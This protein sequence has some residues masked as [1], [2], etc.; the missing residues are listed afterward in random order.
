MNKTYK[1]IL[2]KK[3]VSGMQYYI[4]EQNRTFDDM[5]PL[6]AISIGHTGLKK[7]GFN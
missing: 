1:K 5:E 3:D 6:Q 7:F 4:V 2:E